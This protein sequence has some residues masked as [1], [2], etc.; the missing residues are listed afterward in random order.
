MKYR[1][2]TFGLLL[3]VSLVS[4]SSHVWAQ[5]AIVKK[6]IEEHGGKVWVESKLGFGST[7]AFELPVE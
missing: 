6:I 3:T 7:F 2:I 4:F 1:S 5:D